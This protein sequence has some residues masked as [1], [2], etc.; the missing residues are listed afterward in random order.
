MGNV[1]ICSLSFATKVKIN[2]WSKIVVGT[3]SLP[4]KMACFCMGY[5]QNIGR[6]VVFFVGNIVESVNEGYNIYLENLDQTIEAGEWLRGFL[7][8][9]YK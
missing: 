9:F 6:S 7:I 3:V 5:A 1:C 4:S 2:A 8:Y